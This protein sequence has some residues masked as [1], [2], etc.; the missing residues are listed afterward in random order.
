MKIKDIKDENMK[1]SVLDQLW[2]CLG[3]LAFNVEPTREKNI[4]LSKLIDDPNNEFYSYK[5]CGEDIYEPTDDTWDRWEKA[6]FAAAPLPDYIKWDRN[7]HG[8][9]AK[10]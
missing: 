1:T 2:G 5:E 10:R 8:F 9:I 7:I 3:H 4:L 6:V